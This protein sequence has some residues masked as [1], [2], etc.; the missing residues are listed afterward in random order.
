MLG[1]RTSAQ[2]ARSWRDCLKPER[3]AD[4]MDSARFLVGSLVTAYWARRIPPPVPTPRFS[5]GP[6]DNVQQP[7]NLVMPLRHTSVAGRA[8]VIRTLAGAI[9]EVT[10][11]LNNVG[12]VHFAR[13]DILGGDLCMFSFYDGDMTGYLRD[14]IAAVGHAFDAIMGLVKD[15]PPTPVALH[16][17]EF[18]AWVTAHD[19]FQL[20]EEPTDVTS[21]L[22]DITRQTLLVFHR[23]RN[24][25]ATSYRAYPGFSVAQIRDAL[26]VGW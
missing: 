18:V 15:P 3:R 14:F 9:D 5:I 2:A 16:V 26:G 11:G 12:T 24:I 21:D 10:V 1:P 6:S 22:A 13:F 8:N 19:A 4:Y 25:A 20:P 7:M 23:N 17:D